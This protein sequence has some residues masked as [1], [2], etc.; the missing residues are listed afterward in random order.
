MEL[1]PWLRQEIH[2]LNKEIKAL[3]ILHGDLRSDNILW[4]KELKRALIID[5]HGSTLGSQLVSW[6]QQTAK[7]QPCW[8]EPGCQGAGSGVYTEQ[9]NKVDTRAERRIRLLDRRL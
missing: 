2:I 9:A 4:N 5:F 8:V 6:W 3:G 1:A 7:R